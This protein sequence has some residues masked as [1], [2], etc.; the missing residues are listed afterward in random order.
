MR[1]T[2]GVVR[3]HG[4]VLARLHLLRIFVLCATRFHRR[5]L[6]TQSY[7]SCH[8]IVFQRSLR[9]HKAKEVGCWGRATKAFLLETRRWGIVWEIGKPKRWWRQI[10]QENW[11]NVVFHSEESSWAVD[12][13]F[14][15]LLFT[16][17]R[18]AQ[19]SIARIRG[20][21]R[22]ITDAVA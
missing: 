7:T 15:D 14:K 4:H 9:S 16:A 11:H 18:K 13:I 20:E 6:P 17:R 5:L 3:P 2:G 21:R 1:D 12:R 8:L 22:K 10:E 19:A